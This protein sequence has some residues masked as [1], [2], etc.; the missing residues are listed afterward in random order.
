MA[1]KTY[2]TTEVSEICD[3]YPASVVNWVDSGKL[4]AYVTPGGHRRVVR[5]DLIE[6]LKHFKIPI[7]PELLND[8][9][10]VVVLDDEAEVARLVERAFAKYKDSFEVT[11]STSAIETL[12]EIGQN[13]PD[14]LIID[15][16]MPEMDGLEVCAKLNAIE[17]MK[18]MKIIAISGKR[19][20]TEDLYE[21]HGISAVF[22]K[23]LVLA[24]VVQ[25]AAKLLG[26]HLEQVKVAA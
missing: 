1:N 24:D 18:S 9:K 14:L 2:T 8:K 21:T 20:P 4:K 26:V 10:T 16:V 13:P 15:M 22:K 6:F 12:L 5:A 11:T 19:L 25:S 23:P 3:V 17:N 7:P